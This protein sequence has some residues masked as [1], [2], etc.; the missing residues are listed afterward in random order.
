[1]K[2][3]GALFFAT[4]KVWKNK[5]VLLFTILTSRPRYWWLVFFTSI[6]IWLKSPESEV[7]V[8]WWLHCHFLSKKP[9][10]FRYISILRG[11]KI[12]KENHKKHRLGDSFKFCCP[13]LAAN[14]TWYRSFDTD[15]DYT[16]LL[17][18]GSVPL[19]HWF[20]P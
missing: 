7:P 12:L 5:V 16:I 11:D 19:D 2:K 10:S 15:T 18:I 1:M 8:P 4:S 9:T 17:K 6:H 14:K 20:R 3:K 13:T